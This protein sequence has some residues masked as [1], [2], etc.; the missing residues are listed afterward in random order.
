[1]KKDLLVKL[2]NGYLENYYPNAEDKTLINKLRRGLPND[3]VDVAL[4]SHDF[5]QYLIHD[6]DLDVIKKAELTIKYSEIKPNKKEI[7]I[8]AS[9][10]GINTVIEIFEKYYKDL[11]YN[12]DVIFHEKTL[13]IYAQF[14]LVNSTKSNPR[15]ISI[16]Y[17]INICNRSEEKRISIYHKDIIEAKILHKKLTFHTLL[18]K[19]GLFE[20]KID[21][22]AYSD[23]VHYTNTIAE[24][25]GKQ[26]ITNKKGFLESSGR[27]YIFQ[28][29]YLSKNTEYTNIVVESIL[30]GDDDLRE[31]E[32]NITPYLR[33]FSLYSKSYFYIHIDDIEEYVYD[34]NAF[35]H[36]IISET[37]KEIIKKVFDTD[38]S[39]YYGDF[40]KN[41][42]GGLVIL[43][44]GPTGVGKTSTAEVYAELQEKSLYIV[45]I[46]ELGSFYDIEKRLNTIFDR[47]EKWKAVLLFDE[48]D[49]FLYKRKENR[50]QSAIVGVFL[51]LLDYFSG[52]IF[53]TSNRVDVLDS[54][55]L[56]R[57]SLKITYPS[58]DEKAQKQIWE[59][60]LKDAELTIDSLNLLPKMELNG[61]KIKN[62]IRLSKIVYGNHLEEKKVKVLIEN[63][64]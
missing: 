53:F 3:D 42:H 46:D 22:K 26:Y 32:K 25:S 23:L 35:S 37:T 33:V 52:L 39:D 58:L 59:S 57:V 61:R 13:P 24:K 15:H 41:K 18:S 49:I 44:E 10:H 56:S 54:A 64:L 62:A 4:I 40:I 29:K 2:I 19:Y 17:I 34:K 7:G 21:L 36:L 43:A 9:I 47:V 20:Q 16:L 55:I 50:E 31:I 28:L 14:T 11:E 27:N 48:I 60:K 45:Q 8:D 5:Y 38:S 6:S 51:R 63:Y 1:M 12:F 30:E